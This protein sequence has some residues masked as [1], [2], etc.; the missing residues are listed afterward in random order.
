MEPRLREQTASNGRRFRC[1]TLI[2]SNTRECLAITIAHNLPSTAVIATLESIMAKRGQPTRL[3]L[4]NGSEFR[5]RTSDAWA[6]DRGIALQF[7]QP[8]KPIQNAHI[9]RFNC[10]FRDRCLNQHWFLSLLDAQFHIERYRR[11]FNTVRPH[12]AC[13]PLTPAE[14]ALT[15]TA[16]PPAHLST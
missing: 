2:D 14:Y 10:R 1:L 8:R 15:F 3:S 16:A 7:I 12:E 13:S 5:S 11:A 6:T 4:D 9:E